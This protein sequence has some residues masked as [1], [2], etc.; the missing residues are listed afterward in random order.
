MPAR[1]TLGD[2]EHQV[3]LT[4]CRLGG[5]GYSVPVVE[6]LE[7]RT[8]R[9][10]AQAA[11]FITL[12][13]LERKGLLESRLDDHAVPETGRVRRYFKVTPLALR[14]LQQ[15]RRTLVRLWEGIGPMLDETGGGG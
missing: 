12:R 8:G 10:V 3:L 6:E 1:D 14:R 4:L 2:F 13:R 15:T 9:E 11:V 7:E 5:E